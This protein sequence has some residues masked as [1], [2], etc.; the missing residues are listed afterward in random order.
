[1]KIF[2]I[3]NNIGRG[4]AYAKNYERRAKKY[5]KCNVCKHEYPALHMFKRKGRDVC[6]TCYMAET[7]NNETL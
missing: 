4:D 5:K 6:N 3:V 2:D 1:M 7:E